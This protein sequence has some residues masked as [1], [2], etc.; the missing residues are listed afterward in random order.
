MPQKQ[1]EKEEVVQEESVELQTEESKLGQS[2]PPL[3]QVTTSRSF[4]KT[5]L[6]AL[7]VSHDKRLET[8]AEEQEMQQE[9][10]S[11]YMCTIIKVHYLRGVPLN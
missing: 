7:S 5:R 8:V 10:T 2:W 9:I 6:S 1:V 3:T 11:L 4:W